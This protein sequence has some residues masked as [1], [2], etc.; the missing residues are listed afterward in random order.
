MKNILLSFLD[1]FFPQYCAGCNKKLDVGKPQVCDDCF[2]DLLIADP[3]RIEIE[4]ER[5][6]AKTGY[7]KEFSSPYVFESEGKIH[8]IIH[9]IKYNRRFRIGVLLGNKL[10][11]VLWSKISSWKIDIII[12]VPLHHLKKAERGFNQSEFIAR[13]LSDSSTIPF[14][15]NI[16]KRIRFTESQT[17]LSLRQR[18]VNVAGAFKVSQKKKVVKKNI[19]LVDDV[20]T[21]GATVNECAK[22]LIENGVNE[23]Y[24]CSVAIAD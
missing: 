9:S 14:S 16:I 3:N 13:G 18:E 5:K 22:V 19:L 15:T 4:F 2:S 17:K 8:N 12:P 10:A 7:I 11:E 21:T 23:V 20:I 1:F 24:V 6:F